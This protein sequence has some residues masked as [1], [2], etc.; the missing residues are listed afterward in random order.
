MN[1]E[2]PTSNNECRSNLF[3]F[4]IACSVFDIQYFSL[5]FCAF[6]AFLFIRA[7]IYSSNQRIRPQMYL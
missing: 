6:A 7:V 3:Y 2:Y 4:I 5:F 1:N